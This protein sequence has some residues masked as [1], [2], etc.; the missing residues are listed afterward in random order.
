MLKGNKPIVFGFGWLGSRPYHMH[1]FEKIYNRLGLEF[2]SI[3]QSPLSVLNVTRDDKKFSRIYNSAKGR[4]CLCHIFSLNGASSFLSSLVKED[5]S[6]FKEGVRVE[7]IIWDS[8][9]GTSPDFIYHKAFAKSIF[10]NSPILT[11]ITST[12]LKP[13]FQLFLQRNE[14]HKHKTQEMIDHIYKH[15]FSVPQL[16]LGSKRD[17]IIRYEDMFRYVCNAQSQGIPIESHFW[18]DSDHVRLYH[19]HKDEYIEIV[20]K[21]TKAQLHRLQCE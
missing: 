4:N 3:I 18:E 17:Y 19:D 9:P 6:G 12:I 15:P 1:S 5:L 20:E 8:S 16:V 14:Y 13:V 11:G 7:S 10:P 2:Q 21:F